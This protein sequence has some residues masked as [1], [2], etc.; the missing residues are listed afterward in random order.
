MLTPGTFVIYNG[1]VD[2]V[3]AVSRDTAIL[4]IAG[5]VSRD[6]I[7]SKV[8]PMAALTRIVLDLMKVPNG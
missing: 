1:T 7:G 6:D 2:Y 8:E 5:E 4:H 3:H